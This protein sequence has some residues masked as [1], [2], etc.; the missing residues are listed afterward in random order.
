MGMLRSTA[1]CER[2][3]GFVVPVPFSE[4]GKLGHAAVASWVLGTLLQQCGQDVDWVHIAERL[5]FRLFR[6]SVLADLGIQDVSVIDLD[7]GANDSTP[8]DS[9]VEAGISRFES[10]DS[11]LVEEFRAV[12]S[13]VTER[14]EDPRRL[15]AASVESAAQALASLWE[16]RLL[17][18]VNPADRLDA[19][20][21]DLTNALGTSL[22]S[23]NLG[24][25]L[26]SSSGLS[27]FF[28]LAGSLRSRSRALPGTGT[29]R[30][31]CLEHSALVAV[32]SFMSA[33][34]RSGEDD[35][36]KDDWTMYHAFYGGLFHELHHSLSGTVS[37]AAPRGEL[38]RAVEDQRLAMTLGLLTEWMPGSSIEE[39]GFWLRDGSDN[40]CWPSPEVRQQGWWPATRK[41]TFHG[42]R[43]VQSCASIWDFIE[44]T[45]RLDAGCRDTML[46]GFAQHL[47][48][49]RADFARSGA[50]FTPE[51]DEIKAATDC[52]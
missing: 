18:K 48:S 37:G 28:D 7:I 9:L 10:D 23:L 15:R 43:L 20:R 41:N 52:L 33:R 12:R 1:E 36:Y 44:A 47:Y 11:W 42:G 21:V 8:L 45:E 30:L 31:R 29:S 25:F 2:W 32:T 35:T 17:A 24:T 6:V 19:A 14:A 38:A 3:P 34:R 26:D 50:D 51:Y 4:L 49:R 5:A 13:A 40:K 27:R 16:L 39:L 46:R 22:A